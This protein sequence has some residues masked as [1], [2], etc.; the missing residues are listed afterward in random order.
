MDAQL[1]G[2]RRFCDR[3]RSGPPYRSALQIAGLQAAATGVI[4][5][6]ASVRLE[7]TFDALQRLEYLECGSRLTSSTEGSWGAQA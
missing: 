5:R 3:P 2:R 6:R 1:A 7:E 4:Q